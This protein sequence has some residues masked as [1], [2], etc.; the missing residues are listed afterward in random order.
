MRKILIA[1]LILVGFN[2]FCQVKQNYPQ[3]GGVWK[4]LDVRQGFRLPLVPISTKD[5]NL[6]AI[7]SG[8]AYYDPSDSTIKYHTGFQWLVLSGGVGGGG[9]GDV[10]SVTFSS[11]ENADTVKYWILGT[12]YVAGIIDVKCGLV[13]PGTVVYDSLLSFTVSP[14]IHRDCCDGTRYTTELAHLTLDAADPTND[15]IDVIALEGDQVVVITGTPAATPAKPQLTQCQTE[16][17][18]IYVPAASTVPGGE[19]VIDTVIIYDQN[20]EWLVTG[21]FVTFDADNTTSPFHLTK[22]VSVGAISST[23][24]LKFTSNAAEYQKQNY[25]SLRFFIKL[26]SAFANNCRIQL[27]WFN[28]GVAVSSI[29]TLQHGAYGFDRNN[30]TAYQEIIIPMSDWGFGGNNTFDALWFQSTGTN[31]N[32]F[33]VDWITLT[34]GIPQQQI[35]HPNSF[36]VVNTSSGTATSTQ[37]N[38]VLNIIGTGGVTTSATGKTVTINGSGA[39]VTTMGTFGSS[40]NAEG[41]TISGNTLTLQPAS[42]TFPGGVTTGTQTIAGDKNMGGNTTLT[43]YAVGWQFVVTSAGTETL[44]NTS[45]Y[46]TSFTGTTT[47]TLVLP[48]ATTL[49]LGQLYRVRNNST[50]SITINRN[51]GSNLLTLLSGYAVNIICTDI[52]GAAGTWEYEISGSS[53]VSSTKFGKSGEDVTGGEIRKFN[54][55]NFAFQIDSASNHN[56]YTKTVSNRQGQYDLDPDFFQLQIKR[57]DLANTY[58][59]YYGTI[60]GS[61]V[62]SLEFFARRASVDRVNSVVTTANEITFKS[63]QMSAAIRRDYDFRI[64]HLP[65]KSSLGAGDSLT[66]VDNTNGQLWKIAATDLGIAGASLSK[67]TTLEF[68]SAAENTTMWKTPVDITVSSVYAVNVGSASPSVTFNIAFGSDRTSG[69][70]VFSSGQTS[71]STTTGHTFNSGFNDATIPAGSW[72]WITT[73]AQS[74]TVTEIM[75]QVN[76]TED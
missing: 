22:A 43:K 40:P 46:A 70:N 7:D 65:G 38:D 42:G 62:P 53:V 74:G 63:E 60:N 37:P 17:T 20:V 59:G 36:G 26:K 33:Y 57:N 44:T 8:Q 66:V 30:A 29:V 73:S 23:S 45:L 10:D 13:Q 41:G 15:R 35:Q 11:S 16:L 48:D 3:Y 50:G 5:F 76:Y 39:G 67:S 19:T 24:N 64:K 18:F 72:I 12:S 61:A 2:S 4:R 6:A 28:N 47:H 14:S 58:A 69:T 71:T 1:I 27:V 55:N 54:S 56:L 31:I 34:G 68:A 32:G 9:T 51:G 21:S 75:I 49:K 25:N 52:S